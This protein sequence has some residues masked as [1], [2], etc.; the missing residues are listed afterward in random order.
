M[1]GD[2]ERRERKLGRPG[3]VERTANPLRHAAGHEHLIVGEGRLGRPAVLAKGARRR[4]RMRGGDEHALARD[5]GRF[6]NQ[7]AGLF[8]DPAV[9]ANEVNHHEGELRLAVIQHEAAGVEFVMNVRRREV[10][11]PADDRS[12]DLRGDVARRG[13]GPKRRGGILSDSR[14]RPGPEGKQH[15]P[16]DSS[17]PKRTA[18]LGAAQNRTGPDRHTRL[19]KKDR[20]QALARRPCR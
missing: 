13:P 20:G 6:L 1:L 9:N 11:K 8:T 17:D 4:V 12:P 2:V 16:A 18:M 7:P 15:H 19:R 10:G 14:R 5:A 3:I